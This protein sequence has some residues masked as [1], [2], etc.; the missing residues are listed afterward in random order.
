MPDKHCS[1]LEVKKYLINSSFCH[2]LVIILSVFYI[3][4]SLNLGE[5]SMN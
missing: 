2:V 5:L 1:P 3:Y 4:N